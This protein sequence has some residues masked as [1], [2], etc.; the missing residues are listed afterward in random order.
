MVLVRLGGF[1]AVLL[2]TLV[3]R[4]WFPNHRPSD[5]LWVACPNLG[6]G[7]RRQWF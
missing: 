5:G 2:Y 4:Y 7:E 6:G 1:L 3:A